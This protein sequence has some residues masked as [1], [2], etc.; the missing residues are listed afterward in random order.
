M[1]YTGCVILTDLLGILN[2]CRCNDQ[3]LAPSKSSPRER[4][5][6]VGEETNKSLSSPPHP[7]PQPPVRFIRHLR[8]SQQQAQP[9]IYVSNVV[10]NQMKY[11]SE[12]A[13]GV[14]STTLFTPSRS[15]PT[16]AL[17]F[18]FFLLLLLLLLLCLY[19][20]FPPSYIHV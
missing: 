2:A 16:P 15:T 10:V 11:L 7:L 4:N 8:F 12:E 3:F 1:A 9:I 17:F 5:G 6:Q 14:M 20:I 19:I 13:R 18:F